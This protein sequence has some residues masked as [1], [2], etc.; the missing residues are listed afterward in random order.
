MNTNKW[1]TY[2]FS[3]AKVVKNRVIVPPMASQTANDKGF[4]TDST[5]S[6]YQSLAQSQAG[7]II[8][9]YSYVHPS[10]KGELNQLGVASDEYIEGL[11][12]L[13]N[14]I[15]QSGALAG[16]QIVHAGGKSDP[17]ITGGPLYST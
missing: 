1:T 12:K 9:E 8:V 11:S 2:K 6:H 14:V 17:K 16:L 7:T 10:G 5:I 15:H 3:N 4:V 13:S